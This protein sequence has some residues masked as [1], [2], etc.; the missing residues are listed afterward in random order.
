MWPAS[1]VQ[2]LPEGSQEALACT[3]AR[4]VMALGHMAC[5]PSQ[6]EPQSLATVYQLVSQACESAIQSEWPSLLVRTP[7]PPTA[8]P[9]SLSSPPR[10]WKEAPGPS[11]QAHPAWWPLSPAMC[12]A[13][14]K[15]ERVFHVPLSCC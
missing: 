12:R 8:L 5:L 9:P 11:H 15:Q 13:R 14:G 7:E 3:L 2:V 10:G 6:G 1:G 4:L